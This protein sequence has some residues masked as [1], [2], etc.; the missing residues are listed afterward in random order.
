[1]ASP[2][3]GA[4][5]LSGRMA[6][7]GSGTPDTVCRMPFQPNLTSNNILFVIVSLQSADSEA[8]K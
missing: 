4:T 1:M 3:G 8:L 2:V 5:T 6:I 7:S